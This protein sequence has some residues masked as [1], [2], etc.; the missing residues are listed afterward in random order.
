MFGCTHISRAVCLYNF[1]VRS[2]PFILQSQKKA[3]PVFLWT[4]NL[5]SKRTY[6]S[7]SSYSHGRSS[8]DNPQ[9]TI[10]DTTHAQWEDSPHYYYHHK[11]L[12]KLY[13]YKYQPDHNIIQK[14]LFH[15]TGVN[16]MR[17]VQFLKTL[18]DGTQAQSLGV[19]VPSGEE[20][21]DLV[22]ADP[23]IPN[24]M[25]TFLE[26]RAHLV[27]A[28]RALGS[29]K[30][31]IKKEDVKLLEPITH[32]G[33]VICI[34]MNYRDHC[35]E[36]NVKV[37]MEP[38]IFSKFSDCIIGPSDNIPYPKETEELDWEVELAFI[39]GK[40]GNEV[41]PK[42]AMSHVFGY[43]VAHDVSARDWQMK[44][45]GRQW[46]LGKTMNGFC[47]LGPSIV[48]K[49][50]IL[51]P[52]NLGI[53]CYVND[54]LKQ[55]SNTSNL[56][57]GIEDLIVFLSRFFTLVPGDVIL[58]GTPPGVGVFRKPPEFLKKGDIVKCEIDEI[59]SITN[60]V[61]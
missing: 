2:A 25:L 47:P 8:S 48:M 32:P 38:V 50:D 21:V 42:D 58:T 17:F 59:G 51:D 22:A 16:D 15:T 60:K 34:G 45:N 3:N 44:K 27:K 53:R 29:G 23:T 13:R 41:D 7:N 37:P 10:C 57:F 1:W 30:H 20:I 18:P 24:K 54:V 11:Q 40:V 4:S 52:Q 56:V 61:V 19:E 6:I 36:Q 9:P 35:E 26:D 28:S 55:D 46:L 31:R 43:T 49:E 33:K 5:L 39:I 12:N 14:R